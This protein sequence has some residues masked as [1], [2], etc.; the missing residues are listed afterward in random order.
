MRTGFLVRQGFEGDGWWC[1]WIW[2]ELRGLFGHIVQAPPV[3][4][5]LYKTSQ[6]VLHSACE[7]FI[8]APKP[9]TS[10]SCVHV[11]H[12]DSPGEC[13]K[14]QGVSPKSAWPMRGA[15]SAW[16]CQAARSRVQEIGP[17]SSELAVLLAKEKG[18]PCR[19]MSQIVVLANCRDVLFAVPF[20]PSP[21]PREWNSLK[22]K[23]YMSHKRGHLGDTWGFHGDLSFKMRP[24]RW[25]GWDHQNFENGVFMRRALSWVAPAV[26]YLWPTTTEPSRKV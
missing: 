13:G 15:H 25:H 8:R 4:C 3:S 1:D 16:A 10:Y 11:A 14:L 21:I 7:M 6:I 5:L 19:K 26:S 22:A 20:Q 12:W 9:P 17:Q 18:M 23:Q 24:R 2:L